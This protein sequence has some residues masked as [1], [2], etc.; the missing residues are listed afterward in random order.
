MFD[1]YFCSCFVHLKNVANQVIVEKELRLKQIK[2]AV[3]ELGDKQQMLKLQ[4][5]L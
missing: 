5:V 2:K 3:L 1:L 4:I